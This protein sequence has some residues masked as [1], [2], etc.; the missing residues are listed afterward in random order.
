MGDKSPK[1]V[2]RQEGQKQAKN[3]AADKKKKKEIAAKQ[4]TFKK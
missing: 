4:V 1:S 2:R 3:N